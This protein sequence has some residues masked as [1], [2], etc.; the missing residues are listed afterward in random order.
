MSIEYN[1]MIG[2]YKTIKVSED[3]LNKLSLVV[4][5]LSPNKQIEKIIDTNFLARFELG[6]ESIYKKY[7]ED[8]KKR[9][10][11]GLGLQKKGSIFDI[12]A[13]VLS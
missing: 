5:G 1:R 2:K 9:K 10:F 4:P 3:N 11:Q 6:V 8:S 7:F 13:R 12:F